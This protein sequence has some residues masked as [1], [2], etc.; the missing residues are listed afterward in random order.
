MRAFGATNQR[1]PF[2][3]RVMPQLIWVEGGCRPQVKGI[4][5]LA[6]STLG[7]WEKALRGVGPRGVVR[8]PLIHTSPPSTTCQSISDLT[9][10][11][12]AFCSHPARVPLSYSGEGNAY[13]FMSFR[14]SGYPYMCVL[15][16][17][18]RK[19]GFRFESC[20]RH[21]L[22]NCFAVARHG[23]GGIPPHPRPVGEMATGNGGFSSGW[24][25]GAPR[26]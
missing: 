24:V 16:F 25:Q 26:P 11:C 8:A 22:T 12:D 15:S 5:K 4:K 14:A 18:G 9:T 10:T 17:R 13:V 1:S 20:A 3:R 19:H 2:E 6:I 21:F 23:R 7:R